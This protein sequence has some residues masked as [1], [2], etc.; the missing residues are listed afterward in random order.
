M[1]P[2]D[3]MNEDFEMLKENLILKVDEEKEIGNQG[4]KNKLVKEGKGWE[5]PENGDEGYRQC[6]PVVPTG[7][8]GDK[9]SDD[10]DY[11]S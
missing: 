7:R 8:V 10:P 2:T 4:L 9:I 1:L 6:I 5:T 11:G 3:G